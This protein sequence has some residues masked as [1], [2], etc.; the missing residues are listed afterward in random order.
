MCSTVPWVEG[1]DV[2]G[3]LAADEDELLAAIGRSLLPPG[4]RDLG[5]KDLRRAVDVGRVWFGNAKDEL[6]ELIC[7]DPTITALRAA[8]DENPSRLLLAVVDVLSARHGWPPPG[9]VG[10][11]ILKIGFDRFCTSDDRG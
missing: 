5:P 8:S 6:H 3:L 7:D 1:D 2:E 4:E 11:L 10:A 9:N